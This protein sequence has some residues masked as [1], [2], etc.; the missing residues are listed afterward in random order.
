MEN[1]DNSILVVE[2]ELPLQNV[3][4][5]GLESAGF[6]VVT[7]RSVEQAVEYL[8]KIKNIKA[9]WLDHYLL[10][11]DSGLDLVAKLKSEESNWKDIPI[12]LVSNTASNEKVNAYMNLGVDKYYVKAENKLEEIIDDL[13]SLIK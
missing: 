1:M 13:K 2:D 3:I 10:G 12:F 6:D 9:I 11:K 7:A 5:A 4:K 8:D